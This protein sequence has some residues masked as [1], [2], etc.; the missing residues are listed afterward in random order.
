[1]VNGFK[2]VVRR[3]EALEGVEGEI[4]AGT[5]APAIGPGTQNF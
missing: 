1:M 5:T 2:E 4:D 3:L